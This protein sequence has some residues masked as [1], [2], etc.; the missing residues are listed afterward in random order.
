MVL[1]L[2]M[3]IL[4][5]SFFFL[6]F[7]VLEHWLKDPILFVYESNILGYTDQFVL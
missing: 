2:N 1:I 6:P 3:F 5:Y 7:W 4:E